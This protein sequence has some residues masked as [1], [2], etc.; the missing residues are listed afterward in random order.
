MNQETTIPTEFHNKQIILWI[1][2]NERI[3]KMSLSNHCTKN[4][5]YTNLLGVNMVQKVQIGG[6]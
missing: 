4:W 2:T 1:A 3:A 6:N 5:I